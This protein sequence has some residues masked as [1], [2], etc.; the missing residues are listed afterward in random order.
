[1][2]LAYWKYNKV[3]YQKE[4]RRLLLH[5]G[6]AC[7]V[8]NSQTLASNNHSLSAV[9]ITTLANCIWEAY[10]Y[11]PARVFIPTSDDTLTFS[12]TSNEYTNIS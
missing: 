10:T 5:E 11:T 2:F 7:V 9:W 12:M 3:T 1:M 6:V 4:E 8:P